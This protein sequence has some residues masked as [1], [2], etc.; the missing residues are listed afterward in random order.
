MKVLGKLT[1]IIF[2]FSL[3]TSCKNRNN[4]NKKTVLIEAKTNL[5]SNGSNC[6]T[7]EDIDKIKNYQDKFYDAIIN[8]N[9]DKY[10]EYINF[11]LIVDNNSSISKKE[12][13]ENL[14]SKDEY[15]NVSQ[16]IY[17][18]ENYISNK[19]IDSDE[20]K[21]MKKNKPLISDC[22]YKISK[23]FPQNEFAVFFEFKKFNNKIKLVR[24]R[25]AG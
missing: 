3:I 19:T 8:K 16:I 1:L 13:T 4:Q 25:I 17:F 9:K 22:L 15:S 20:L 12:F 2:C 6:I 5:K 14:N 7:N 18:I 23:V 11:P 21:E 24:I 10:I